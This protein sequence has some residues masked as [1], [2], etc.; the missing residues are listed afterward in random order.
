MG[1]ALA[2]FS[3]LSCCGLKNQ[4]V[5]MISLWTLAVDPRKS[6]SRFVRAATRRRR[7]LAHLE[8]G[9]KRIIHKGRSLVMEDLWNLRSVQARTNDCLHIS[10]KYRSFLACRKILDRSLL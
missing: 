1:V 4:P 10:L 3:T 7:R 5:G 9:G 6:A 8:S 2:V